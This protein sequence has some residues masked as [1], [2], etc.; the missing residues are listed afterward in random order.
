MTDDQDHVI[1]EDTLQHKSNLPYLGFRVAESLVRILPRRTS[2]F[3]AA[4]LAD[5]VSLTRPQSLRGLQSNLHHVSP[6]LSQRELRKLT[7]RNAEHLARSWVDVMELRYRWKELWGRLDIE[8]VENFTKA[9]EKGK[10]VVVLSMHFG[11]WE[12]G[13][14]AWNT[15][16]PGRMALLA[17]LLR[18]KA[19]H[20]RIVGAREAAGVQVFPVDLEALRDRDDPVSRHRASMNLRGVMKLLREGGIIAIA[21]D[22]DIVGNG[23]PFPFFGGTISVPIG[24]IEIAMRTGA[25]IVPTVLVRNKLRITG[26]PFPEIPYDPEKPMEEEA[27]RVISTVLP[28]FEDVIRSHPEQWHVMDPLWIEERQ[29]SDQ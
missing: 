10:G 8:D 1:E 15:Q 6:D 29:E 14:A 20:D 25:S 27:R 9:V 21:I 22:R 12:E 7:R 23:V 3:L 5:G 2:Y 16:L 26:H 24:A 18:P 4:R 13:L 19:L 17:E 11:A 28:I